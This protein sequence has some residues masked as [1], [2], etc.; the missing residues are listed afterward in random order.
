MKT[1]FFLIA[2][3]LGVI[4]LSA[5]EI[6]VTEGKEDLG[7]AKNPVLQVTIYESTESDV[8]KAWKSLMKGY[9]AKVTS[10]EVIFSDNAKI[11]EL[12]TNTVDTYAM[13][14]STDEGVKFSVAIDLGGAFVNSTTHA[15]YYDIAE[16]I[17][18]DFA[19][20]VCKKAVKAK[21]EAELAKQKKLENELK[22]LAKKKEKLANDIT[23]WQKS[24]ANAEKEIEI[25][26]KDQ[27]ST[28]TLIQD[29][30][31]VVEAV[32]KKLEGIK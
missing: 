21:Y 16:K 6:V 32:L 1:N 30:A 18:K 13:M 8:E 26:I 3:L 29:Q 14:S 7:G 9:N 10:K 27:E 5:Q 28:T 19:V 23:E 24:I 15:T 25:N 4:R 12:S 17:V 20:D 11:T 2:L 31:K 22:D